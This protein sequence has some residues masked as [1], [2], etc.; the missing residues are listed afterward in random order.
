MLPAV[1]PPTP[2]DLSV[3]LSFLLTDSLTIDKL[4]DMVSPYKKALAKAMTE[5]TSLTKQER[6]IAVRKAQLKESIRALS[7]LCSEPP[8]INALSLSDAIRLMI[9]STRGGLSRT[10]IRDKLEEMGYDLKKFKNAM[11]SIHTA[12]DRMVESEEFVPVS[13]DEKKVE[14]G[15][16]LKPVPEPLPGLNNITTLQGLLSE[17]TQADL[18][19]EKE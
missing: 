15:P 2:K 17:M 3:F 9:R 5:W 13:S 16:E 12:V 14:A 10:G 11:A 4:L 1:L 8:D 6:K 18:N 19:E 7:A